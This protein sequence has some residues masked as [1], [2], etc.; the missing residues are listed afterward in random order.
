MANSRRA[1]R[2][3]PSQLQPARQKNRRDEVKRSTILKIGIAIL[4]P[5][6]G[7]A[8]LLATHAHGSTSPFGYAWCATPNQGFALQPFVEQGN[9]LSTFPLLNASAGLNQDEMTCHIG[10]EKPTRFY[11]LATPNATEV[12]VDG[13]AAPADGPYLYQATAVTVTFTFDRNVAN[14][15]LTITV[16]PELAPIP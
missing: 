15:G 14:T 2:V 1:R 13:K 11:L 10:F 8:I 9:I 4:G 7:A 12:L 16:V 5:A 6:I 3:Q